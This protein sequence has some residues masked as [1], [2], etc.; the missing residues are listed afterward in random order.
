MTIVYVCF[1]CADYNKQHFGEPGFEFKETQIADS[2][3]LAMEH[4]K[5]GHEVHSEIKN[6]DNED[7]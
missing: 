2:L 3:T 1:T 6:Y 4:V 5:Q 7:D